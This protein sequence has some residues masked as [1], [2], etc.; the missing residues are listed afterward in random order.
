MS[1]QIFSVDVLGI[2]LSTKLGGLARFEFIIKK[3]L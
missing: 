3:N 2:E 1:E